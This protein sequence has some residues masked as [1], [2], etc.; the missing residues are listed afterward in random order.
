MLAYRTTWIVKA[1]QMQ[2]ALELLTAE[3]DRT[4]DNLPEDSAAR[5]YTPSISPNVLVFEMT[6]ESEAANDQFWA[7]YNATPE[8][9][10]FWKQWH[11]VT[12]RSIGTER[13]NLVEVR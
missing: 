10:Q 11:D 6:F 4:R 7:A 13:W 2:K 12:E 1:G 3:G 5:V 9:A 8:A